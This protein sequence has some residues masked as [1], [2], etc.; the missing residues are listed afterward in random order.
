MVVPD[1]TLAAE[2]LAKWSEAGPWMLCAFHEDRTS[3]FTTFG[4]DKITEM[5]DWINRQ[6]A[7]KRNIYFHVN[8]VRQPEKG[9]ATKGDVL[10]LE[11][12][13]VDIDPIRK[14]PLIEEQKRILSE[15]QTTDMLP[16]PTAIIFSGG[17]YQA[18]WKLT[19]PIEV[20]GDVPKIEEAERF[21]VQIAKLLS[22]DNCHNAD[23]IMRL[24]GTINWPN[25]TKRA[26]GQEPVMAN[27]VLENWEATYDHNDSEQFMQAPDVAVTGSRIGSKNQI[28]V[29]VSGNVRRIAAEVFGD[30]EGMFK[31]VS[32]RVRV[33]IVQGKDD[34][35]PLTGGNSRSD[36]VWAVACELAR[37]GFDDDTMYSI[38]TDRD[39]LISEHV[40]AQ[41]NAAAVHR[42]A[43]RT[44]QRAKEHAEEPWLESINNEYALIESIG[45]SMRI[46][47][48]RYSEAKGRYELEFHKKEGFLTT[49]C[50][51]VVWVSGVDA[52]G[53]PTE[54][55][56]QV[57]KWWL[58]HPNRRTYRE[59]VFYPQ[60]DFPDALNLWRGFAV[61]PVPGDCSLYL[62]HIKHVLCGGNETYYGYMLRWMAHAVQNPH[63]P[64]QVAIVIRG[65]QGTG[66]GTF[67]KMFGRLFGTHYKYVNNP[68]HV[69]GQFNAMLRDAVVVFADE[70]FVAND[71]AGES[72]LKS[73]ITEEFVRTEQKN[74]DNTESRNCV[75][76]IMATNAEWA[77]AAD[78]EDRRFF[79]LE[80]GDEKRV[81]IGYFSAIHKQMDNGG[82][83]ALMHYL[84]MYDLT[85]FDVFN[86][87]K[88]V[89]LRK[90]QAQ[91]MGALPSF[92]MHA[93]E[94][95]RLHPTHSGWRRRVLKEQLVD[96][97]KSENPR[98]NKN[99]NSALGIYLPKFDV[100]T[101]TG[102]QS[103]TW[104]DSR[105]QK[106]QSSSR[107]KIWLFPGLL[108]CRNLWG[109][110]T[111]S[112]T[113]SWPEVAPD[114]LDDG[115]T[116]P[117][118][119]G[120]N[121]F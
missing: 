121:A 35:K 118:D 67:A 79:V 119:D 83:E 112:D 17:G 42:C 40:L 84:M 72:A 74:I 91:S 13:H 16:K 41:G 62:D 117:P 56:V 52:K 71:A 87:P 70:C 58:G 11:W 69:T 10:R 66:K 100:E 23:R 37:R 54:K 76:L 19:T 29:N 12:F 6:Q 75:H 94:E 55:P 109:D 106:R 28:Q 57:G 44:I 48:E 5:A 14:K 38:L 31:D 15:L 95:G 30:E 18:F 77:V 101:M 111:K 92:M 59:V 65:S 97:F 24:P 116:E 61:S 50:N 78:M 73:L 68:K 98:F 80:A 102:G 115:L 85:G 105:G 45:G 1:T 89:E 9:K 20:G 53:N 108:E 81:D 3:D 107:P 96:Q 64:G 63:R 36:W 114:E 51:Q 34:D 4:P 27:L 113:R 47:C 26:N 88:T 2:F 25:A 86:C 46:A 90:Q 93:L 43:L 33:A 49:Y 22:A 7:A 99:V 60:K 82:Y 39:L 103:E 110:V 104:V 32:S 120:G 8:P 21:N